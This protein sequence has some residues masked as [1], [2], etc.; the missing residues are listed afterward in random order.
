MMSDIIKN[1]GTGGAILTPNELVFTFGSLHICVQF[2]ENRRRNATVRV[3][4][5]GQTHAHTHARTDCP[6]LYTIAMG[7]IKIT[8]IQ[9]PVQDIV[10]EDS[11]EKKSVLIT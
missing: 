11:L 5:N 1:R 9:N 4:T 3:S 6:M 7:Q 10:H 2:G 8:G